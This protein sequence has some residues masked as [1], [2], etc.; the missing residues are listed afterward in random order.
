MEEWTGVEAGS[1]PET[2]GLERVSW[3]IAHSLED[4]VV[5]VGELWKSVAWREC[6]Q[7]EQVVQGAILADMVELFGHGE[8]ILRMQEMGV[9]ERPEEELAI[10][11][12]GSRKYKG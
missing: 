6:L 2:S 9:W 4:L 3:A 7:W 11:K 10:K 5:E 1:R 12:V 8:Q